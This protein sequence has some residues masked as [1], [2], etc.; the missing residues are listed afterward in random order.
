MPLSIGVFRS[1]F[2]PGKPTSDTK[3]ELTPKDRAL[4]NKLVK[5]LLHFYSER[6]EHPN[7][8]P[9][10]KQS[11]SSMDCALIFRQSKSW[12]EVEKML[13][14]INSI[15]N[16][17]IKWVNHW[18]RRINQLRVSQ[19]Q[20]R[21]YKAQLDS[22]KKQAILQINNKSNLN[23]ELL[24]KDQELQIKKNILSSRRKINYT[25]NVAKEELNNLDDKIKQHM[26][27]QKTVEF[28]QENWLNLTVFAEWPE[29]S[30][31]EEKLSVQVRRLKE[32][33]TINIPFETL[34]NK[35]TK[36]IILLEEKDQ[37][38]IPFEYEGEEAGKIIRTTKVDLKETHFAPPSPSNQKGSPTI[39]L[40]D[41]YIFDFQFAKIEELEEKEKKLSPSALKLETIVKSV[42]Q[43]VNQKLVESN[44]G[45]RKLDDEESDI[46]IKEKSILYPFNYQWLIPF[47]LLG[48]KH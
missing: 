43:I 48:K 1:F 11:D 32:P 5:D 12:R 2:S 45:I 38:E 41:E 17:I 47:A 26:A 40:T 21:N 35:S 7:L 9:A 23:N 18:L 25:L 34:L 44:L 29:V 27:C 42:L 31:D 6:V 16:K 13:N 20:I 39:N 19:Q 28:L 3:L 33:I 30:M 24:S 46:K 15:D 4:V 37:Q 8:R 22:H 36:A 10:Y 14:N